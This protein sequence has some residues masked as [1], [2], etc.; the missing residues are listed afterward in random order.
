MRLDKFLANLKYGS[1]N[2]IKKLCKEGFVSVNDKIVKN[3]D[4]NLIVEKDTVKVKGEEV[5]YKENVTLAIN[6]PSGYIC[7]MNFIHHY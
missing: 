6:K 2:D 4:F 1:R 7:S 5:F 3:S